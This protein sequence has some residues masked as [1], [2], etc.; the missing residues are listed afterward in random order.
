MEAVFSMLHADV[1][2]M[3]CLDEV[4]EQ[5]HQRVVGNAVLSEE[6][7]ND[8]GAEGVTKPMIT[9]MQKSPII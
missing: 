9:E 8:L 7:P 2:L 1:F 6:G 3:D 4:I 5:R